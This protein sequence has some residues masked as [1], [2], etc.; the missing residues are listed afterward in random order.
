MQETRLEHGRRMLASIDPEAVDGLQ[1]IF[2]DVAPD[3][4]KLILEFAWSDIYA[5]KGL[6]LKTR[7]VATMAA[8]AA[9]GG[10]HPQLK[11]HIKYAVKA[12]CSR[13]EVI[14]IMIHLIVFCG[15]PTAL[16][17]IIAA[18]EAFAELDAPA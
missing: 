6:D 13:T 4:G 7:E 8:L 5:R 10:F 3:L 16:N 14:E 12:G 9:R 2:A 18:R 11:A 15:V 1:N 17:G